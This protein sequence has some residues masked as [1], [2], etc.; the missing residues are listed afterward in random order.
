MCLRRRGVGGTQVQNNT[1]ALNRKPGC[2]R[3]PPASVCD[4]PTPAAAGVHGRINPVLCRRATS[5]CDIC[6]ASPPMVQSTAV[7]ISWPGER[8]DREHSR[9][10]GGRG[11][12]HGANS[13][14]RIP[15]AR[16]Q[17]A[18]DPLGSRR[19]RKPPTPLL[20]TSALGNFRPTS[21]KCVSMAREAV[22]ISTSSKCIVTNQFAPGMGRQQACLLL[23]LTLAFAGGVAHEGLPAAHRH[24][25]AG[26]RCSVGGLRRRRRARSGCV[27]ALRG[28]DA[29]E[30]DPDGPWARR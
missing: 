27:L 10:R 8:G 9:R 5:R 2:D 15:P 1:H 3:P 23:A 6:A 14:R 30:S 21:N 13:A 18:V 25:C 22:L 28:G 4:L 11:A 12:C 29:G 17:R 19:P 26:A 16:A 20:K 24:T 7:G